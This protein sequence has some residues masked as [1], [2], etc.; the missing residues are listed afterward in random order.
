MS[1]ART[2]T[3]LPIGTGLRKPIPLTYM[4]TQY[5][6]LQPAAQP[7]P[8]WSIH[9]MTAPPCTLPPKLTSVGSAKNLRVTSRSLRAMTT[10][11]PTVRTYEAQQSPSIPIT[12][13][14][15]GQ[16]PR[17]AQE[18]GAGFLIPKTLPHV[19]TAVYI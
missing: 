6:P 8:A 1:L 17:T 19:D 14:T 9:F 2:S 5:C 16:A 13:P 7:Y 15:W 11:Y 4:V 3:M 10:L 18:D 12:S